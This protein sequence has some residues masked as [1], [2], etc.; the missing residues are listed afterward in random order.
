MKHKTIISRALISLVLTVALCAGLSPA[1]IYGAVGDAPVNHQTVVRD[2]TDGT[3]TITLDVTGDS[4]L[5]VSKAN[6]IVVLDTSWSMDESTGNTE[7]QYIKTSS[8]GDDLYGLVDGQYVPIERENISWLR[9]MLRLLIGRDPYNYYYNGRV[10]SG[11]RYILQ[12]ANQRRIDAAKMAVN[13]LANALLSMNNPNDS[14]KRDIVEMAL[15]TFDNNATVRTS[16]K[17]NAY[18]RF[19]TGSYQRIHKGHA[20]G[21]DRR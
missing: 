16:E 21:M 14:N 2:E 18:V 7:E 5:E 15:V 10:Y 19:Y 13:Q 20:E 17:V 8:W 9:A 6:V 1:A 11:E 12:P 3:Y 4:V